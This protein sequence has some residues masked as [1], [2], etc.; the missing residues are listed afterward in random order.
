MADDMKKILAMLTALTTQVGELKNEVAALKDEVA[1]LNNAAAAV[2]AVAAAAPVNAAAAV[3][4]VAAAA[5]VNAAAAVSA[6]AAAAPVNAAAAVST[7]AAAAP[8]NAAHQW[9]GQQHIA[10]DFGRVCAVCGVQQRWG[11][12]WGSNKHPAYETLAPSQM[13]CSGRRPELYLHYP[14]NSVFLL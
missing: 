6:V 5:P 4:A 9:G 3:G 14:R 11:K 8:V 7:V 2:G 12:A 1:A 10:A 13:F